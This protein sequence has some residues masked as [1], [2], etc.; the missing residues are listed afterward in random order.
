MNRSVSL[1][2]SLVSL[3]L[4][5]L[6]ARPAR[7]AEGVVAVLTTTTDLAEIVRAVGGDQVRVRSLCTGPEDP[8]FLDA[9]PSFLGMAAEAELLVIVGMELEVGYLPLMLRDGS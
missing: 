3:L 1:L 8:H 9:R 2:F 6:P 5:A 7:A 4:L